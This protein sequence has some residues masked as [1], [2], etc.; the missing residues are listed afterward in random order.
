MNV[1]RGHAQFVH[2]LLDPAHPALGKIL[3]HGKEV[4]ADL[5]AATDFL[6]PQARDVH[7]AHHPGAIPPLVDEEPSQLVVVDVLGPI[8]RP[9]GNDP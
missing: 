3:P 4:V 1:K 5:L 2:G 7:D 9:L 8:V 6:P